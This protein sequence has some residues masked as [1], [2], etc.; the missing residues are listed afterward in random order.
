MDSPPRTDRRRRWPGVVLVGVLVLCLAASFSL[1]ERQREDR[2]LSETLKTAESIDGEVVT[3]TFLEPTVTARQLRFLRR[4]P[5][6]KRLVFSSTSSLE[7]RLESLRAIAELTTIDLSSVGWLDE[8]AMSDIAGLPQIRNL[9]LGKSTISDSQLSRLATQPGLTDLSLRDCRRISDHSIDTLTSLPALKQLDLVGTGVSL[10]GFMRL[11]TAR[12][13]LTIGYLPRSEVSGVRLEGS[14]SAV[15]GPV[16]NLLWFKPLSRDR[17]TRRN[18]SGGQFHQGGITSTGSTAD[19]VALLSIPHDWW[20]GQWLPD[21]SLRSVRSITLSSPSAVESM[22][23]LAP[24]L[25]HLESITIPA[26]ALPE[27]NASHVAEV[28]SAVLTEVTAAEQLAHLANMPL[29]HNLSLDVTAP[30]E[31]AALPADC[32]L[33]QLAYLRVNGPGVDDVIVRFLKGIAAP[34]SLGLELPTPLSHG[35]LQ[36]LAG[37]RQADSVRLRGS[38]VD[39]ELIN[40]LS[41]LSALTSLKLEIDVPSEADLHP[42]SSEMLPV[43]YLILKGAGVNDALVQSLKRKTAPASLALALET[44]LGSAVLQDLG[45]WRQITQIT[46]R[47]PGVSRALVEALAQMTDLESLD[48]EAPAPLHASAL[49]PLS[50]LA[51]LADIALRGPGVDDALVTSLAEWSS[52]EVVTVGDA[53]VTDAGVAPFLSLPT[54]PYV[55]AY[56]TRISLQMMQRL[57]DARGR[58]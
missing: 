25:S 11:R 20:T 50:G 32:E 15:F 26:A 55:H 23:W 37:W 13:D 5:K 12:Q 48:L 19:L 35:T 14:T 58:R 41:Q 45:G 16:A 30:L 54:P 29:L 31:A 33:P 42:G 49:E 56:E 9:L 44:P 28:R 43:Q 38:G 10:E 4:Y 47:G 8:T 27:L 3:V 39:M 46:L 40:A 18:G 1:L 24:R 52:L 2:L 17:F 57:R 53:P 34:T 7:G 36:D 6:L 22:A 51:K 21:G